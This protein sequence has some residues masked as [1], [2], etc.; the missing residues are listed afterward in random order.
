MIG[1]YVGGE[2][3][4]YWCRGTFLRRGLHFCKRYGRIGLINKKEV[5]EDIMDG[6]SSSPE[7]NMNDLNMHICFE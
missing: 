4:E 2:R 1:I 3:M 7:P 6:D 5:F